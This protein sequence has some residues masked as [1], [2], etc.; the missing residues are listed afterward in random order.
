[1]VMKQLRQIWSPLATMMILRWR[2]NLLTYP[3]G[4][5]KI[6]SC[7][8]MWPNLISAIGWWLNSIATQLWWSKTFQSPHVG[9]DWKKISYHALMVT[10]RFSITSHVGTKRFSTTTMCF[11]TP[12]PPCFVIFPSLL[13]PFDGD[14]NLFDYHLM[15]S[16]H[17]K[18]KLLMGTHWELEWNML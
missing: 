5:T 2:L 16:P 1:M 8:P 18:M 7:H 15:W 9:G 4:M 13:P 12:H 6:H 11:P 14:W 10:E 3:F 17:K